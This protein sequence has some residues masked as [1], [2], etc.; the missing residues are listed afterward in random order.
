MELKRD[1]PEDDPQ[2]VRTVAA[3][4]GIPATQNLAARCATILDK[5]G[6]PQ[7]HEKRGDGGWVLTSRAQAG[8][9]PSFIYVEFSAAGQPEGLIEGR[10]AYDAPPAGDWLQEIRD[11]VNAY[12]D[13]A[14]F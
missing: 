3:K 7:K 4:Y 12:P 10:H 1:H 11:H 14:D 8:H 13:P 6:W 9:R 5:V 2:A